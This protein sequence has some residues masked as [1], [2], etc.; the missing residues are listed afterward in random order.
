M[1]KK[2]LLFGVAVLGG[3]GLA[4]WVGCNTFKKELKK[5]EKPEIKSSKEEQ[6]I[7]EKKEVEAEETVEEEDPNNYIEPADFVADLAMRAHSEIGDDETFDISRG[8]AMEAH[9]V[10]VRSMKKSLDFLLQVPTK[11]VGLPTMGEFTSA[12]KEATEKTWKDYVKFTEQPFGKFEA[13]FVINWTDENGVRQSGMARVPKEIRNLYRKTDEKGA[14]IKEKDSFIE[15]RCVKRLN[16]GE[17]AKL[18]LT[19]LKDP[20]FVRAV[21]L[22]RVSYYIGNGKYAGINLETALD[23][24]DYLLNEF[25]V[26]AREG[27]E[28]I[29]EHVVF[30]NSEWPRATVWSFKQ[31]EK[32][33]KML[34]SPIVYS[35]K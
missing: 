7:I 32:G 10:H 18:Q 24:L 17:G 20:K 16:E 19:G 23:C 30:Y 12:L 4:C 13:W 2:N 6:Q 8:L 29:Y 11:G 3:I 25:S 21:L 14:I 22:W 5:T 33:Y 15:T 26:E 34:E 1:T 28:F 9:T 35:E 27:S 31:G